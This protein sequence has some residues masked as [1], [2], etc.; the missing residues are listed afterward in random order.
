MSYQGRFQIGAQLPLMI[1]TT[2]ATVP[3][4]PDAAPVW[5]LFEDSTGNVMATG[6]LYPDFDGGSLTTFRF[7]HFLGLALTPGTF[8]YAIRYAVSGS[9]FLKT[10]NVRVL[11]GGDLR[12]AVTSACSF[13]FAENLYILHATDAGSIFAGKNPSF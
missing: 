11:A 10:V 9:P 2:D 5:T 6:K 8:T 13:P 3:A 4:P 12:G 7:P 1:V